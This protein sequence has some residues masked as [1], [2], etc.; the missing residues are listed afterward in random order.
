V[1]TAATDNKLLKRIAAVAVALTLHAALFCALVIS[2]TS[3]LGDVK[4]VGDGDSPVSGVDMDLVGLDGARAATAPLQPRQDPSRQRM[5]AFEAMIA[6]APSAMTQ[7]AFAPANP[8]QSISEALNENPFDPGSQSTK[9]I[10]D[11]HVSV[12]GKNSKSMNDL[13]KAIEPCWNRIADKN[14]VGVTLEVS[15]SAMGNLSK[16]P[17]IQRD[18]STHIDDRVLRSESQAITALAQCG[19]YLIAFGQQNVEVRFP[20][21]E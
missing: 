4:T 20:R 7:P 18:P 17:V 16:P 15:F 3:H 2:T 14:T 19:P 8:A 12:N 21:R 9:T 1:T 6:P 11:D 13:W 5:D 10:D